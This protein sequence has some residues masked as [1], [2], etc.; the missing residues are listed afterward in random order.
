MSFTLPFSSKNCAHRS[1]QSGTEI[2][3]APKQINPITYLSFPRPKTTRTEKARHR[4]ARRELMHSQ[5]RT[6]LAFL[7][8]SP[9]DVLSA[10]IQ[11]PAP[12]VSSLALKLPGS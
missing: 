11:L 7:G 12:V 5:L 2:W 3:A 1:A 6:S 4:L 8:N 9:R 10:A